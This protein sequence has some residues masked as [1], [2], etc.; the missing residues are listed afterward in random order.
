MLRCV[1]VE[2]ALKP[3]LNAKLIPAHAR[4]STDNSAAAAVDTAGLA[5]ASDASAAAAG[6][7]GGASGSLG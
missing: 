6:G 4:H 2:L 7:G 1:C 3:S 5:Q